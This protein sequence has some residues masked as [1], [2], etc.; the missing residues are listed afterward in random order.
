MGSSPCRPFWVNTMPAKLI[1]CCSGRPALNGH[2]RRSFLWNTKH[3]CFVFEGREL[4][5]TELNSVV[6]LVCKKNY[7]LKPFVKVVPSLAEN[8]VEAPPPAL[9]A[10]HEA[11]KG[12]YKTL[13]ERIGTAPDG[14]ELATAQAQVA[15]LQAQLASVPLPVEI[16]LDAALEVVL[17]LAPE[18]LRKTSQGRKP[19]AAP[20]VAD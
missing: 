1:I 6:E 16:T 15:D 12:R 17:R 5:E 2:K 18:K 8:G 11:L 19:D 7:D 4:G 14:A 10:E 20:A 13:Q 9:V 3:N